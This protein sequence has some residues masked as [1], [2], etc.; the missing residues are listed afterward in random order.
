MS[1]PQRVLVQPFFVPTSQ[2]NY[3]SGSSTGSTK[4]TKCTKWQLSTYMQV[5][6]ITVKS[7]EQHHWIEGNITLC[8]T[9]V[10][11]AQTLSLPRVGEFLTPPEDVCLDLFSPL[12]TF[13]KSGLHSWGGSTHW[14]DSVSTNVRVIMMLWLA[15][16]TYSL[17]WTTNNNESLVYFAYHYHKKTF[18]TLKYELRI[19]EI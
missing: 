13:D 6:A 11:A 8:D 1:Q 19:Y 16:G 5:L 9:P 17:I 2:A 7:H 14:A 10:A 4:K 15:E 18:F 12:Q 3:S